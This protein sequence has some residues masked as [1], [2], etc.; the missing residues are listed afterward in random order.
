MGSHEF[1]GKGH[2]IVQC[3]QDEVK[4]PF[5]LQHFKI[6]GFGGFGSIFTLL[7]SKFSFVLSFSHSFFQ[8]DFFLWL[9]IGKFILKSKYTLGD[10]CLHLE[11]L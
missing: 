2:Y 4:D 5:K 10:F 11:I 8:Q 7:S 1:R 9:P 6:C 3:T